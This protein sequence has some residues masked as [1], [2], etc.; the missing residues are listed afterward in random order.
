[1]YQIS[2]MLF[3]TIYLRLCRFVDYVNQ[4][5]TMT[6]LSAALMSAM[7]VPD[8]TVRTWKLSR[9]SEVT[10]VETG[11][12]VPGTHDHPRPGSYFQHKYD[13]VQAMIGRIGCLDDLLS[14]R[15]DHKLSYVVTSMLIFTIFIIALLEHK[16][17]G[18]HR[19]RVKGSAQFH[20]CCPA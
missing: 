15:Y 9:P 11:E 1:M 12:A 4:F 19:T 16:W 10:I 6:C 5:K 18:A 14:G 7:W 20:S 13:K 17:G 2:C 3:H 8:K